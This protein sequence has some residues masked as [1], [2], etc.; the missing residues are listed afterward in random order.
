MARVLALD[1]GEKRVGVAVSDP[2]GMT[3][4]GLE[5]LPR[6]GGKAD[7]EAVARLAREYD[8]T[9]VVIGLPLRLD[10]DEGPAA[11]A[12]RRFATRLEPALGLPVELWDERLTTAEVEKVLLSGGV[13]RQRRRQ[14]RDRL[15]AIVL[16]QSWLDAHPARG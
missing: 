6:R 1:L 4:Q 14:E 11:L 7:R 13:R 16:L 2:L 5:T 10:G 3:A 15:A 12:A 9:R 8:I